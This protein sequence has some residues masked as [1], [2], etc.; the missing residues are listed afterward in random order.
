MHTYI[1]IY[2]H[3]NIH[4]HKH[5]LLPSDEALVNSFEGTESVEE[6]TLLSNGFPFILTCWHRTQHLIAARNDTK[7]TGSWNGKACLWEYLYGWPGIEDALTHRGKQERR[8][9]SIKLAE[10]SLFFLC[11]CPVYVFYENTFLTFGEDQKKKKKEK[12]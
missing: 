11:L 2:L 3:T 4:I 9:D 5:T 6:R 8:K 7:N 10:S 1:H 12:N